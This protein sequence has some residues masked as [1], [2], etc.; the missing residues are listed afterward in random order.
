VANIRSANLILDNLI[1]KFRQK[2][3]IQSFQFNPDEAV[4]YHKTEN[5]G[6]FTI[7]TSEFNQLKTNLTLFQEVT[8]EMSEISKIL[9]S[10]DLDIQKNHEGENYMQFKTAIQNLKDIKLDSQGQDDPGNLNPQFELFGHLQRLNPNLKKAEY[11]KNMGPYEKW[12]FQFYQKNCQPID[13]IPNNCTPMNVKMA[14]HCQLFASLKNITTKILLVINLATKLYETLKNA[15]ENNDFPAQNYREN[16]NELFCILVGLCRNNT[17][18]VNEF[19]SIRNKKSLIYLLRHYK[20]EILF[21][22]VNIVD[23]PNCNTAISSNFLTFKMLFTIFEF[24][25]LEFSQELSKNTSNA[26]LSLEHRR[27]SS[28]GR[29][30]LE[31]KTTSKSLI[32]LCKIFKRLMQSNRFNTKNLRIG[33]RVENNTNIFFDQE[34]SK[35]AANIELGISNLLSSC[36][37]DIMAKFLLETKKF[38]RLDNSNDDP[39]KLLTLRF[40]CLTGLFYHSV[41]N[42]FDLAFF[43]RALNF[44]SDK[45]ILIQMMK[46][47]EF[48]NSN[49]LRAAGYIF[50]IYACFKDAKKSMFYF[51]SFDKILEDIESGSESE[52]NSDLSTDIARKFQ[53]KDEAKKPEVKQQNLY[54]NFFD[55][56]NNIANELQEDKNMQQIPQQI[57]QV[58]NSAGQ[59]GNNRVLDGNLGTNPNQSNTQDSNRQKVLKFREMPA[60]F[61][62]I[63]QN[64]DSIINYSDKIKGIDPSR[65]PR[66]D[67]KSPLLPKDSPQPQDDTSRPLTREVH[68]I[69]YEVFLPIIFKWLQKRKIDRRFSTDNN[70]YIKVHEFLQ[71]SK[72]YFSKPISIHTTE[73]S[74]KWEP[75]HANELVKIFFSTIDSEF[76]VDL[77]GLYTSDK[78]SKN[79]D[80]DNLFAQYQ[81]YE[82]DKLSDDFFET[83]KKRTNEAFKSS[84]KFFEQDIEASNDLA[85]RVQSERNID[86]W[87]QEGSKKKIQINSQP[88]GSVTVS[89]RLIDYL[90]PSLDMKEA[91]KITDQCIEFIIN[92]YACSPAMIRCLTANRILDPIDMQ[93]S[94]NILQRERTPLTVQLRDTDGSKIPFEETDTHL[95]YAKL[96][97]W[98]GRITLQAQQKNINNTLGSFLSDREI[99][100]NGSLMKIY[101]NLHHRNYKQ[102]ICDTGAGGEIFDEIIGFP[103]ELNNSC[104]HFLDCIFTIMSTIR[105]DQPHLKNID[106]YFHQHYYLNS[107]Y[108]MLLTLLGQVIKFDTPHNKTRQ[109][110]LKSIQEGEGRLFFLN[111]WKL[112]TMFHIFLTRRHFRVKEYFIIYRNFYIIIDFFKNLCEDNFIGFKRFFNQTTEQQLINGIHSKD[113]E[114][115]WKSHTFSDQ[116]LAEIILE[117]T[118]D[119]IK[120]SDLWNTS[121]RS[122]DMFDRPSHI[123]ILNDLLYMFT[124]MVNGGLYKPEWILKVGSQTGIWADILYRVVD[125]PDDFFYQ[126]KYN[127]LVYLMALI[128]NEDQAFLNMIKEQINFDRMADTLIRLVAKLFI[129]CR[130]RQKYPNSISLKKYLGLDQ[131]RS[132]HKGKRL[133][134]P[135]LDDLTDELSLL[136]LGYSQTN[137]VVKANLIFS[138]SIMFKYDQEQ[139]RNSQPS[140]PPFRLS[141]S[142]FFNELYYYYFMYEEE[143]SSHKVMETAVL[144]MI[145]LMQLGDRIP[146]FKHKINRYNELVPLKI[147]EQFESMADPNKFITNIF[148]AAFDSQEPVNERQTIND[149]ELVIWMFVSNLI[150]SVEIVQVKEEEDEDDD[151][152][153]QDQE[154]EVDEDAEAEGAEDGD[155]IETQKA[156]LAVRFDDADGGDAGEDS[157]DDDEVN[158]I[159]R[160]RFRLLP[161]MFFYGFDDKRDFIQKADV[162]SRDTKLKAFFDDIPEK[163]LIIRGNLQLY[164][165][166][167]P[168]YYLCKAQFGW[169]I[170]WILFFITLAIDI[171]LL[172]YY[173][174]ITDDFNSFS[175]G[176][177]TWAVRGL[178]IAGIIIA[179]FALIF[180]VI[181]HGFIMSEKIKAMNEDGKYMSTLKMIGFYFWYLVSAV[182]ENSLSRSFCLLLLC[183]GLGLGR[184]YIFYILPLFVITI[185]VELLGSSLKAILVNWYK[186]L[187]L[188]LI[189]I[190][191]T[192]NFAMLATQY[193]HQ[194]FNNENIYESDGQPIVCATYKQCVLNCFSFGLRQGNGIGAMLD[195][196]KD[197]TNPKFFSIFFFSIISFSLVSMMLLAA[198]FGI[199]VD[200]FKNYKAK[201]NAHEKSDNTVCYVCGMNTIDFERNNRNFKQHIAREHNLFS[202]FGLFM[203][204]DSKPEIDF[205]GREIYIYNMLKS[206]DRNEIIPDNNSMDFMANGLKITKKSDD[207]D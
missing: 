47:N 175:G 93:I 102:W 101:Y 109:L 128:E 177:A 107:H 192:N 144:M 54:D 113:I 85:L 135:T 117:R 133:Y 176:D 124:E 4:E 45:N 78:K 115:I 111:V 66:N 11:T 16:L 134:R 17:Q 49:S 68:F 186:L 5:F 155:Q 183:Y 75:D 197:L 123:Y 52:E 126:L 57:I 169:F 43:K 178:S 125:D 84:Q 119:I 171:L 1:D 105:L 152:E 143:F 91:V 72:K 36:M 100:Q 82:A 132:E 65:P 88:G 145:F 9:G 172:L 39:L 59:F 122:I 97:K 148:S 60:P 116:S 180:F 149:N 174:H 108:F 185:L 198:F 20:E 141:S 81:V 204:L 10:L 188:L 48:K 83:I 42:F 207:D 154:P 94:N 32:F 21:M 79:T 62:L 137:S 63:L 110:I 112:F 173:N 95:S 150:D 114:K 194:Q 53:A 12:I 170:L 34:R 98:Q 37:F 7:R 168:L 2:F 96:H 99:Y 164:R 23:S 89:N 142:S 189:I 191:V 24:D 31:S 205:S 51:D 33:Q 156:Q 153:S 146:D 74:L 104:Q 202:Y 50:N 165:F 193:L 147:K 8:Q 159:I 120:K 118:T 181:R 73:H 90:E 3:T 166:N 14:D 27:T 161:E 121:K 19:F 136:N 130:N 157:G 29:A 167:R 179:G 163:K 18:A 199:V 87:G 40:R 103:G 162:S 182:A 187:Y 77:L 138:E 58:P 30:F 67:E 139:A 61:Q 44:F 80:F 22:I 106:S 25:L 151:Q 46:L 92:F 140:R 70:D 69:Y 200:S 64:T 38:E 160:H 35:I 127:T 86:I 203:F 55:E 15:A 28:L 6:V 76:D 190:S 196:T 129:N 26:P 71:K 206:E 13:K 56:P 131:R 195:A 201:L 184:Y 158:P 41:K